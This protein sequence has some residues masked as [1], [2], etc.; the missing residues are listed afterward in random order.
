[1]HQSIAVLRLAKVDYNAMTSQKVIAPVPGLF[2][3][4][5]VHN[6]SNVDP[7]LMKLNQLIQEGLIA[8]IVMGQDHLLLRFIKGR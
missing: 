5:W 3:T 1:V 6:Q 2:S 4:A 7:T 8:D